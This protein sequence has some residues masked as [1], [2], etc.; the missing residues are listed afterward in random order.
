MSLLTVTK[1]V[2][3]CFNW[4]TFVREA[5]GR[6]YCFQQQG[7]CKMRGTYHL[8]VHGEKGYDPYGCK[9]LPLELDNNLFGV[10]LEEWLRRD[11]KEAPPSI[12]FLETWWERNFYP[13]IEAVAED[14]CQRGL[15]P[16]GEYIIII[17]W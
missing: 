12:D 1:T 17:D 10:A 3:D 8:E 13:S 2:V 5:Y 11:P 9:G 16:V 6:P 14:L 7:G 15:L 4:D